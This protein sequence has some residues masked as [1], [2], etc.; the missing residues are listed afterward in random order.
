MLALATRRL[1]AA[2]PTLFFIIAGAFFLMHMAPGGPF[3]KERQMPPEIERRL[4]A[5]Y[6]LDLPVHEQLF[7]YLGDLAQGD[8]GPSMTYKDKNVIDI[9]AEG[10]PTSAM[11]GLSAMGLALFIGGALGIVGALNQNRGL[12]FLVMALAILGVCLPP[13][14]MG[15]VMQQLFGVQLHWLPTGG[16]YR[17]EFRFE[18]LFLPVLTLSL[19]MIAIISRLMRASMIEAMRSNAIRTARAKGLPELRV[20]LRHAL[21]IALLPIVSYAGPALAGVM[22]GSF[23]IETVYQLPGIG[24]QFVLAAQQ[25]DYTLV[26][27]VV[28]VYSIL[29]IFLNLA[30]DLLYRVLD[31]RSRTP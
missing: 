26:M 8:L 17:D 4:L 15:P 9:I 27:G 3:T 10:A 18:Y 2:L 5:E 31:P 1:I 14:V 7:H 22:A 6:N 23:V 11:L 16:L 29:I 24:K 19:P 12:D 28:L 21:P 25:R 30:A 20:I 13:L